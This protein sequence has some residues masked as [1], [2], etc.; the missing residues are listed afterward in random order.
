MMLIENNEA[1]GQYELSTDAGT[2]LAAYRVEGNI[3]SFTHTEVPAE[4]E[5]QG[6]GTRLV[7]GALE[8]V[9]ARGMKAAPLCSFVRRYMET[10]KDVQDLL[11]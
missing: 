8:D 7:A 9:R 11:A 10:H 4:M 5:G 2:A 1:A 6:V 3:V